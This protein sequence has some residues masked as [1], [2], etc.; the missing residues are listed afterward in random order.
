MGATAIDRRQAS[1]RRAR[2]LARFEPDLLKRLDSRL[3]AVARES[4]RPAPR[5]T[6]ERTGA[7]GNAYRVR[8]AKPRR[9][10]LEV[11]HDQV[12]QRVARARSGRAEPG[13]LAAIFELMAA[14]RDAQPQN[15]HA[16]P[17]PHRHAERA[18]RHAGPVP[19]GGVGR[20]GRRS[21]A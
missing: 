10:L 6:F 14:S 2:L 4:S 15:V 16:R 19:L 21:P 13:V 18:V 11:G 17:L 8:I 20:R 3:N 12:R 9:R 5:R 7:S 1:R